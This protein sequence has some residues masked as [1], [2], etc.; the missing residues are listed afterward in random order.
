MGPKQWQ[1]VRTRNGIEKAQLGWDR[2][3][4]G[5]GDDRSVVSGTCTVLAL[6][7]LPLIEGQHSAAE[8]HTT[9]TQEAYRL[10]WLCHHP[11]V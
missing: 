7:L 5:G 8:W 2:G 6:R 3:E 11:T 1:P 10:V 9:G 4:M